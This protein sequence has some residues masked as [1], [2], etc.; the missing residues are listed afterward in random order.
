MS[1]IAH[2]AQTSAERARRP[3]T[4]T[5]DGT[6]PPA[7]FDAP[8]LIAEVKLAAPSAGTLQAPDD[9]MA[10]VV[11]QARRE[12]R[13]E[14]YHTVRTGVPFVDEGNDQSAVCRAERS[15]RGRLF[16]QH[17]RALRDA[18][19]RTARL[20]PSDLEPEPHGMGWRYLL[21]TAWIHLERASSVEW[22]ID[23]LPR[24][25]LTEPAYAADRALV[26]AMVDQRLRGP[27][28]WSVGER[29]LFACYTSHLHKCPF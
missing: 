24:R 6:R 1:L 25:P 23:A 17:V 19:D 26:L 20:W 18:D 11:E 9:P 5:F 12:K 13:A 8:A 16:A 15:W 10:F 21:D 14:Q 28:E 7:P 3:R 29:E 22:L 27:S 4:G 2:M